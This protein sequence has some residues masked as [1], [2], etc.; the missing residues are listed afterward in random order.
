MR[1]ATAR[2]DAGSS[3]IETRMGASSTRCVVAARPCWSCMAP[4][5]VIAISAGGHPALQFA[6]NHPQRCRALVLL[7]AVNQRIRTLNG[8]HRRQII[9]RLATF[10]AAHSAPLT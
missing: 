1:V 9:P 4:A 3:L 10:L 7:S 5:A 6:L 2:S 8:T